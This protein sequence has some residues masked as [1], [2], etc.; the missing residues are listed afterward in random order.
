MKNIE[1]VDKPSIYKIWPK[2]YKNKKEMSKNFENIHNI[3]SNKLF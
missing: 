3:Q 1:K 2:I